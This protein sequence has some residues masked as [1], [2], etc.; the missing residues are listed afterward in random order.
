MIVDH[1]EQEKKQTDLILNLNKDLDESI[2]EKCRLRAQI[3]E[4]K[5]DQQNG[6]SDEKQKLQDTSF[7]EA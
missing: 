6:C 4:L 3:S 2:Q 5:E 1:V 7:E